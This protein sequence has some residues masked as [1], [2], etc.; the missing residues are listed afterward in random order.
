MSAL[1]KSAQSALMTLGLYHRL[2]A[3]FV[4]DTYW[5]LVNSRVVDEIDT[6]TQ[7]YR[8]LL[9]GFRKDDLIFDVGANHGRKTGIFLT[10]GARVVAFDPDE[11]NQETLRQKFLSYRIKKKPVTIMGVAVS[12]KVGTDTFWVDAPG[13]GKNTLNRKWVDTLRDDKDRFGKEMT[14]SEGKQVQTTTLAK[15]IEKFGRPYFVKID[16]EGHEPSVVRGLNQPVPFL[17][18]EV[19][20][21]EFRKEGLEC[22]EKLGQLDPNGRFNYAVSCQKGLALSDWKNKAAF[23]DIFEKC[24][25]PCVEVFWRTV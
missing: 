16:V 2:K 3:S 19:N 10:L 6:E 15:M 20:L 25:E 4:Y 9:K 24:A 11:L 13:S 1:K 17:S 21:P 12:D 5:K 7:F 8:D 14:F 22:V 23:A 18:F